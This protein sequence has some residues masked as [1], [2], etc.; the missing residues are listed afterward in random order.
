[1]RLNREQ[2]LKV[3]DDFVPTESMALLRTWFAHN[4][5]HLHISRE[6]I[7]K[8]G[9]FRAG[10]GVPVPIISVN[11]N[12]NKFSFLITLLHEMAHAE[13]WFN[14]K[15]KTRPHG[16]AWKSAFSN[17]SQ[18]Y[19]RAEVF[20]AELAAAFTAYLNNPRAST[21]GF[22]PLNRVLRVYDN[23]DDGLIRIVDLPE[24]SVFRIPG[25]RSFVKGKKIRTRFRCTCLNNKR[26]YLFNPMAE[27]CP[28][29]NKL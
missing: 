22:Q 1:M 5:V 4:Q 11:Y 6:R 9:D 7:S 3:P 27:V 16:T 13:V 20:P 24:N 2:N 12:L 23:N 19:L 18:P 29:S 17:L 14:Y 15:K 10:P 8:L 25:G 28:E 21:M 26:I